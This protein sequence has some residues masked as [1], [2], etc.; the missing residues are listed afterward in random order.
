MALDKDDLE[1]IDSYTTG[2]LEEL[3]ADYRH[4][5]DKWTWDDDSEWTLQIVK[6]LEEKIKEL[7]AVRFYIDTS[8]I[9]D[10]AITTAKIGCVAFISGTKVE[11]FNISVKNNKSMSDAIYKWKK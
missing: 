7:E 3:R 10:C 8:V 2:T 6:A 11:M 9:Q 4:Y 5:V 1:I